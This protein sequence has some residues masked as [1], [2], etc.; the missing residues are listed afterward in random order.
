MRAVEEAIGRVGEVVVRIRGHVGPGEVAV[1]VRGT[2]ETL[3]A[4]A[5]EEIDRGAQVLVVTSRGNRAVD[6][7]PWSE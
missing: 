1:P 6:V 2:V 7:I 3:I 5:E 4:Y